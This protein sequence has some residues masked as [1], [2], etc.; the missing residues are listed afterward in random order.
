MSSSGIFFF[1]KKAVIKNIRAMRSTLGMTQEEVAGRLGM[2]Q[3]AYGAWETGRKK[4]TFDNLEQIAGAFGCDV[5]D[6][7]GGGCVPPVSE[8]SMDTDMERRDLIDLLR[9]KD[10]QINQLLDQNRALVQVVKQLAGNI[11]P[12]GRIS[13]PHVFPGESG[14]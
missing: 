12:E 7:V 10:E 5:S 4:L 1:D 13:P 11:A 8:K 14:K 2:T 9:R 6:F 3:A